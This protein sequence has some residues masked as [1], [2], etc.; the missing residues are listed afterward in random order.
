MRKVKGNDNKGKKNCPRK[1][2]LFTAS[3][4]FANMIPCVNAFIVLV[5]TNKYIIIII[6][7]FSN[8]YLDVRTLSTTGPN[9][10]C[11]GCLRLIFTSMRQVYT[12]I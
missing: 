1:E 8:D 3:P 9:I 5:S 12:L 11:E 6:S 7:V 2:Q 10:R 4:P